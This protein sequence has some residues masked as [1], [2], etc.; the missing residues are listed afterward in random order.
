[1]AVLIYVFGSLNEIE[2]ASLLNKLDIQEPNKKFISNNFLSDKF[3]FIKEDEDKNTSNFEMS[4]RKL[5]ELALE[6]DL[7]YKNTFL[8]NSNFNFWP[9]LRYSVYIQ[10]LIFYKIDNYINEVK[11][12]GNVSKIILINVSKTVQDL[13]KLKFE[14]ET[15]SLRDEIV[16]KKPNLGIQ[17]WKFLKSAILSKRTFKTSKK[18]VLLIA[19]KTDIS[20]LYT[21]KG[22]ITEDKYTYFIKEIIGEKNCDRLLNQNFF[23]KQTINSNDGNSYPNMFDFNIEQILFSALF[24]VKFVWSML[25]SYSQINNL[26][27]SKNNELEV[28]LK[29]NKIAFLSEFYFMK[30]FELFLKKRKYKT[31]ILSNEMSPIDNSIVRIAQKMNI[32]TIGLQHGI[33]NWFNVAYEFSEQE[34]EM[35]NPFPDFLVVWGNKEFDFLQKNKKYLDSR[36]KV[37]G[38]VVL[39]GLKYLPSSKE[40]DILTLMFATQPQPI[41]KFRLQSLKDFVLAANKFPK[42]KISIVVR[43]HPREKNELDLYLPILNQLENQNYELDFDK[44]LF[45]QLNKIDVLVTSFS[46]VAFDSMILKKQ[47]VLLDYSNQ[48]ATGLIAKNVAQKAVDSD[49]LFEILNKFQDKKNLQVSEIYLEHLKYVYDNLDF[50]VAQK[51]KELI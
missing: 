31:I 6:F 2:T 32:K 28:C 8:N 25:K 40:N 26:N 34:L 44:N 30:A 50:D 10:L 20:E 5:D 19:T 15:I 37:L 51:I 17:F 27:L 24:N 38:N 46:S 47:I 13:L 21:K 45:L 49:S 16:R 33:I 35:C 11:S 29:H 22:V 42:D 18:D 23:S 43:L 3:E 4:F 41:L 7:K 9:H 1:M 39:D 14:I 12:N 48:D 36:I